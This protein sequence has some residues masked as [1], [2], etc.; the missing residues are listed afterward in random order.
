MIA[1]GVYSKGQHRPGFDVSLARFGGSASGKKPAILTS[2][3][4]EVDGDQIRECGGHEQLQQSFESGIP[5][6]T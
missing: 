2:Q 4:R 6:S 5:L 3:M 1:E